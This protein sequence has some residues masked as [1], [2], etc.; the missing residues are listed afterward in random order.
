LTSI[1]V[2]RP[3]IVG[4]LYVKGALTLKYGLFG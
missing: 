3:S 1:T 4:C 2:G